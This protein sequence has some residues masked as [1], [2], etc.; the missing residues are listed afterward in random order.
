MCFVSFIFFPSSSSLAYIQIVNDKEQ[1]HFCTRKT[2]LSKHLH[3]Q[4]DEFNILKFFG[5]LFLFLF[6]LFRYFLFVF[7][8]SSSLRAIVFNETHTHNHTKYWHKTIESWIY[9]R[10]TFAYY[11]DLLLR[12]FIHLFS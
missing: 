6:I 2:I 8:L 5:L 3:L 12:C 9:S 1:Q 11:L 4:L 10:H 7:V